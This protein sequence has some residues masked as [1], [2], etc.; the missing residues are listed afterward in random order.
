LKATHIRTQHA[1]SHQ[2]DAEAIRA[3]TALYNELTAKD[4][5]PIF[6]TKDK[7]ASAALKKILTSHEM[8]FQLVLPRIH[9]QNV[10]ERAIQTF[11]NHYIAGI[12]ST[13]KQFPLHLWDRLVPHAIITLNL[14]RQSGV[15]PKVSAYDQLNGPFDF[16]PTP[17]APP[18]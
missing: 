18:G 17:I 8:K 14:L 16:H 10:V 4:L 15:N 11:K 9:R 5:K 2:S 1:A 6:Q 3:Y 7:E 13:D 12:C